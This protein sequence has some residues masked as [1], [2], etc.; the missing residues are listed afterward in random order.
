MTLRGEEHKQHWLERGVGPWTPHTQHLPAFP[1]PAQS[2]SWSSSSSSMLS[3]CLLESHL[4]QVAGQGTRD[5]LHQ[6]TTPASQ[7][8]TTCF[9]TTLNGFR[10]LFLFDNLYRRLFGLPLYLYHP[11]TSFWFGVQSFDDRRAAK[12]HF[13]ANVEHT[14]LSSI[15]PK[16]LHYCSSQF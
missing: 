14:M 1:V 7:V 2:G 3:C 11:T 9:Y 6:I 8:L 15:A 16:W 4:L 5:Q 13:R 10:A 12:E